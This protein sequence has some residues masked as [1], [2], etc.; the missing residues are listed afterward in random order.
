M[1]NTGKIMHVYLIL[2]GSFDSSF[3][4]YIILRD[5]LNASYYY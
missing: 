1:Q 3:D 2:C 4:L 5:L